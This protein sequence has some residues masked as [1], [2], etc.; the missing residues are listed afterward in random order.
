MQKKRV[1]IEKDGE[2]KNE[3]TLTVRGGGRGH[4]ASTV[5]L[6][7]VQLLLKPV[8]IGHTKTPHGIVSIDH[9]ERGKHELRWIHRYLWGIF[10][11]QLA[12][13]PLRQVKH[14]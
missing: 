10:T 1:R 9:G 11:H 4:E 3:H 2:K 5:E 12:T 8:D 14:P 13:H 6:L 7:I